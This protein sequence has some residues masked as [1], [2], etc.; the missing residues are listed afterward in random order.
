MQVETPSLGERLRTWAGSQYPPGTDAFYRRWVGCTVAGEAAGFTVAAALAE[1]HDVSSAS[2]YAIVLAAGAIE[3][4]LLGRAQ[5]IALTRLQ[6][7]SGIRRLWPVAT[8]AA[9][10]VGWSVGLIMS[11]I[12]KTAL[13]TPLAWL[14]TAVLAVVLVISIPTAQF[15]LLRTAVATA[16]QWIRFNAV[17]WLLGMSWTFAL[18]RL[19]TAETPI[20]SEI[21]MYAIAGALMATTVALITGLCWL[22]WLKNG[23]VRT[24]APAAPD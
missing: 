14:L 7:P 9:A 23:T 16:S 13:W 5:A 6:L 24:V 19:I 10:V 22:S 3:G 18:A 17:A 11:G 2:D 21:G 1:T 20:V 4:A 8:S 15:L 12:Q